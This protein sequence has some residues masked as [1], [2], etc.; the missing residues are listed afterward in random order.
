MRW[1]AEVRAAV[2]QAGILYGIRPDPAL[3][4]AIIEKETIHGALPITGT[5][6]PRGH[7]SYGPMQ[8]LDSTAAMHGISDPRTLAMPSLGIR[9]GTF[10]LARLLQK[11]AGDT[12]RAIAAYN[13][14]PGLAVRSK[15]TGRFPNQ[16][17]VDAVLGFW[18]RFK[19]VATSAAPA[20]GLIAVAVLAFM[21]MRR[22]QRFAWR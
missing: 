17:Y 20:A 4:H 7:I 12:A 2:N 5:Q 8:V 19:T 18:A 15:A 21:L 10:E 11:F 3:V 14:G 1:D 6:E 16:S 13:G 22:R 9:I